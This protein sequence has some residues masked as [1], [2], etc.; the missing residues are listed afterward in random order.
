MLKVKNLKAFFFI[1]LISTLIIL[2]GCFFASP[3]LAVGNDNTEC[4]SYPTADA[5]SYTC[6]TLCGKTWFSSGAWTGFGNPKC[7]G[8]D[9]QEFSFDGQC[10]N[11]DNL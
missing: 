5:S 10:L 11:L 1:G 2:G 3:V 4:L 6:A 9:S 8:D 7:C